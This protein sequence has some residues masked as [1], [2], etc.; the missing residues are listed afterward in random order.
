MAVQ[1]SN[2][3]RIIFFLSQ[4]LYMAFG[5]VMFGI[6][7]YSIINLSRFGFFT[8][9]TYVPGAAIFVGVGVL[10]FLFGLL[11]ILVLFWQKKPLMIAFTTGVIILMFLTFAAAVYGFLKRSAVSPISNRRLT[12][13]FNDYSRY[14]DDID[15]V[16]DELDCCGINEGRM[17]YV[18]RG[19]NGNGNCSQISDGRRN[20]PMLVLPQGCRIYLTREIE[21]DLYLVGAIGMGFATAELA[22][23]LIAMQNFEGL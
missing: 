9:N 13:A 11:G 5:A 21:R 17:D 7:I 23:L 18:I 8:Q 6:G 19:L 1:L 14:R 22:G 16:E 2:K 10:K 4:L 15:T 3:I 20:N 12:E